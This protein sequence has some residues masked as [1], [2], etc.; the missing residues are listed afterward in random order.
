MATGCE[1]T[2]PVGPLDDREHITAS[3]LPIF[4]FE[5]G[6]A[7]ALP[8]SALMAP[9]SAGRPMIHTE[10][11][12]ILTPDEVA[13]AL[14][15]PTSEVA[16]GRVSG[17]AL[18]WR[19]D[20][21]EV[22]LVVFQASGVKGELVSLSVVRPDPRMAG[23]R[24]ARAVDLW[25]LV[26]STVAES[27]VASEHRLDLGDDGFL[28]LHGGRTV[29]VAWLDGQRVATV[30]VTSLAGDKAWM[31]ESAQAIAVLMAERLGPGGS[32]SRRAPE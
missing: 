3:R 4:L 20:G 7:L 13:A 22:S 11:D 10:R 32:I 8:P 26:T 1:V 12:T 6:W 25:R 29:Q 18:D 2:V 15:R 16:R 14:G 21:L 19:L 24:K 17:G 23:P 27:A 28:A 9:P 5:L 31:M 30:T